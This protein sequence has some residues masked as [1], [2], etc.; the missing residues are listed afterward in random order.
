MNLLSQ[1]IT[2]YGPAYSGQDK[3]IFF[4]NGTYTLSDPNCIPIVK[5]MEWAGLRLMAWCCL[6]RVKVCR[7]KTGTRKSHC[8]GELHWG[9][10]CSQRDSL[11]RLQYRRAIF[12]SVRLRFRY[13]SGHDDRFCRIGHDYSFATCSSHRYA[14]FP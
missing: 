2:Q 9:Y 11:K 12:W 5:T 6:A 13:T 1:Y 10:S 14:R 4:P 7:V 8:S 3:I